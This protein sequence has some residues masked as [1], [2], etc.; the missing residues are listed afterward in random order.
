MAEAESVTALCPECG[1]LIEI[2]NIVNVLLMLHMQNTC[3]AL[4]KLLTP[5]DAEG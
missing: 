2:K 3:P 5:K 1:E 4:A